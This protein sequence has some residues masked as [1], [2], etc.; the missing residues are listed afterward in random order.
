M[1]LILAIGFAIAALLC[2]ST[3]ASAADMTGRASVID[4]DTIEIHWQRI[5]LFRIDAPES[6]QTCEADGQ[7]Y[8]CGQQAA[9]ARAKRMGGRG[10]SL[11]Y[12]AG[13]LA[14]DGHTLNPGSVR[15]C[16]PDRAR[17][18]GV[19]ALRNWP[20]GRGFLPGTTYIRSTFPHNDA[21]ICSRAKDERRNPMEPRD[22]LPLCTITDHQP[23]VLSCIAFLSV[24]LLAGMLSVSG[25]EAAPALPQ[26]I[27]FD[28]VREGAVVGHHQITFRQDGDKLVVHSD[29]KIKVKLLFFTVYRYKQTREEMWRNG[30]VIALASRADDDGT[31]YD[32]KGAAG[33]KGIFIT[34][35]KLSW[36]LPPDSVPA[37]YWNMSMVAGKGPLVDAQS[38]RVIDVKPA[39]IG[40][41]KITAGGRQIVA[42][43]CRI[44]AETPRDVWYDASGRWVKLRITGEDGSVIE[45][46]L[47]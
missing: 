19:G 34:S 26:T 3:A 20:E 22:H 21:L 24:L 7:T 41:E 11:R 27:Q 28:I 43:H 35:G 45:W 36:I 17:P 39:R 10:K 44:V 25:S 8:R 4:G 1:R 31:P 16:W 46:V 6:Q 15:G 5:R 30:K 42:T 37:S 29:V 9:I 32:I 13:K 14:V 38:G 18:E 33:P 23:H 40:E 12:I 2:W 47:K